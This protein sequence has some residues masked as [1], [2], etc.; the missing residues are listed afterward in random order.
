M[1]FGQNSKVRATR[2]GILGSRGYPS[3]YGGF[4]TAVRKIAPHFSA[5]GYEVTVYSRRKWTRLDSV[6]RDFSVKTVFTL[7]FDHK[8]FSTLTYGFTAALHAILSRQKVVLVLNVANGFWIPLLKLARIKVVTNVDGMEWKRQNWGKLAKFIFKFGAFLTIKFSDEL[9]FDSKSLIPLWGVST[10]KNTHY[11]PY[12]AES[13]PERDLLETPEFKFEYVLWVAR[14]VPENSLESFVKAIPNL[15]EF[16]NVVV[17]GDDGERRIQSNL[18]KEMA[19][20]NTKLHFLGRVEDQ[21]RLQNIWTHATVYFHGHTVGGTNP[22]LLQA[23]MFGAPIVAADNVF[24]REVLDS[25]ALFTDS[26]P[27]DIERKIRSLYLD[28]NLRTEF[29]EKSKI[30]VKDNY[31]WESVLES[32]LSLVKKSL[33]EIQIYD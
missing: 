30:N 20:K 17:V 13:I 27:L 29:S 16:I 11:I 5:A 15:T 8:N 12:G 31:N 14:L 28:K 26:D 4:E 3:Y 1:F 7:G 32:Y 18:L 22:S 33:R 23:M 24:N 9:V 2:I 19:R 21:E 25:A 10:N 6:D